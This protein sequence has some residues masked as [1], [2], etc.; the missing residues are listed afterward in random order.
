M[1]TYQLPVAAGSP[2]GPLT[3]YLT[4]PGGMAARL[5]RLLLHLLTAWGPAAGPVLAVAAAAAAAGRWQLRRRQ[6]Q[7]YADHAR[8]V[9]IL[10]PPQADPAGAQA[11]WGHL[12]GLL[13]PTWARWWHGQPH[14]GWEYT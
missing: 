3:R 6:Q 7:A 1:T 10:A 9:T 11:L 12:T 2:G 4:D 8:Q 13:R 14:L 5:A